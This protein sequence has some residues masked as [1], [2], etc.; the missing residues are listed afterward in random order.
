MKYFICLFL[1]IGCAQNKNLCQ[2]KYDKSAEERLRKA[3]L[4]NRETTALCDKLQHMV[5]GLS[6]E[7]DKC[8]GVVKITLR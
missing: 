6:S 7:L 8:A 5:W 1:L 3:E 4:E 2:I